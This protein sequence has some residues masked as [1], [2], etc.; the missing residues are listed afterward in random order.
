MSIGN[1]GTFL[2]CVSKHKVTNHLGCFKTSVLSS[3]YLSREAS[4]VSSSKQAVERA[5]P[6]SSVE[7]IMSDLVHGTGFFVMALSRVRM[8]FR[9]V[10]RKPAKALD[11]EPCW[12]KR[13]YLEL[14]GARSRFDL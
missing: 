9:D 3:S 12:F 1:G 13:R 4:F 11:T 10:M 6:L 2:D 14:P 7:E 5:V 8:A